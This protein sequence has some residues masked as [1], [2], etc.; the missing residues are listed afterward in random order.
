[1]DLRSYFSD[2]H[3]EQARLEKEFPD[4]EVYVTSVF[5]RERNSTAGRTLSAS[6][7]NAARVITD[8]THR[9]ATDDEV[10]AF[11]RLQERNRVNTVKSEQKKKQQYIVVVDNE[12]PAEVVPGRAGLVTA[13]SGDDD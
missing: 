12:K 6:Y 2:L 10:K 1:M 7:R 3:R 5:H 11:H 8:G 13:V 9:I 4:Q